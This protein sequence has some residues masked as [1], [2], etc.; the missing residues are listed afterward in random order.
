MIS[1]SLL[2][3][4]SSQP[5]F[6]S[7]RERLQTLL[8]IE[9]HL[10]LSSSAGSNIDTLRGFRLKGSKHNL[11][12]K[13]FQG[14]LPVGSL[15]RCCEMVDLSTIVPDVGRR[16]GSLISVLSSGSKNSTGMVRS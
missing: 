1:T 6:H 14:I 4:S 10:S 11:L 12:A 7:K 2:D 9:L 8:A 3:P 5:L 13:S 15:R 16:T